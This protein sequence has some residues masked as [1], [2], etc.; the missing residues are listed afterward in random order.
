[1]P[2]EDRYLRWP[3]EAKQPFFVWNVEKR[4]ELD[5]S[6]IIRSALPGFLVQKERYVHCQGRFV[7]KL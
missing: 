1:M 3:A 5:Y 4:S 2:I 7:V 6:R